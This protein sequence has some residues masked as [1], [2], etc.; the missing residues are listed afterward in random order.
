MWNCMRGSILKKP[1][2]QKNNFEH[3]FQKKTY[4]YIYIKK[5]QKL[6]GANPPPFKK[7]EAKSLETRA[8]AGVSKWPKV[9]EVLKGVQKA[10]PFESPGRWIRH[11]LKMN[12]V[13]P[14]GLG[15]GVPTP[16]AQLAL[17]EIGHGFS[18]VVDRMNSLGLLNTTTLAQK[19]GSLLEAFWD[20]VFTKTPH[21]LTGS[22]WSLM[23]LDNFTNLL[24][25]T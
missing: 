12:D 4:I 9:F 21:L 19:S 24:E 10:P 3:P 13:A 15:Y 6:L 7:R 1:P 23:C 2:K 16:E 25:P 20:R 17:L 22:H 8:K 11:C 14:S 18:T 5:K